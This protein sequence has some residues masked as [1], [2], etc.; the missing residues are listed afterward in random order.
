MFGYAKDMATQVAD[1]EKTMG[2]AEAYSDISDRVYR[3]CC[4]LIETGETE[5]AK[6]F[7]QFAKRLAE[8][9]KKKA[10]EVRQMSE[11]LPRTEAKKPAEEVE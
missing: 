5:T 7:H 1:I 6:S 2:E 3:I 8:L 10:D 11:K 9:S 4:G